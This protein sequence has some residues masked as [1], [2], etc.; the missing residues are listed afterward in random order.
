MKQLE[1]S[2]IGKHI[3]RLTDWQSDKLTKYHN[4]SKLARV[5]FCDELYHGH[6]GGYDV[7]FVKL[8]LKLLKEDSQIGW[9]R[10][11]L[12][13]FNGKYQ[14][15]F[16]EIR[17]SRGMGFTFNMIDAEKMFN[18]DQWVSFGS[19]KHFNHLN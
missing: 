8:I 16:A 13:S 18:F 9:F 5:Y 1:T 14:P 17:T 12:S 6:K 10:D 3:Y 11:Q 15:E 2:F 4:F 7:S 19:S